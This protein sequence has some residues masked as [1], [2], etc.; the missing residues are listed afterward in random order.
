MRVI[1][2]GHL[3]EKHNAQ[4]PNLK[5]L[6]KLLLLL[7]TFPTELSPLLVIGVLFFQITLHNHGPG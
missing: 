3:Q 7:N 5:E 2:P 6:G 1:I 4:F